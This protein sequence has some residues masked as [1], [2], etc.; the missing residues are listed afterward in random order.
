[1]KCVLH[2]Y[3]EYSLNWV[4]ERPYS[5]LFLDMGLGKTLITLTAIEYLI[6]F[7]QVEKVLV[8]APLTVAQATWGAEIEKWDHLQ[9][10]SLSKVLGSPAQKRIDALE[11]EADIYIINPENIKWLV[12][13]YGKDWP[14]DMLVIDELS[15]FKDHSTQR[16]KALRKVR[17]KA[18]RVIGMTGT[19]APNGLIN[20]WSQQYLIDRGERLEKTIGA[21]RRKYFKPGRTNGHIVYDYVLLPGAEKEIFEKIEDIDVSMKAKDHLNLPERTDNLVEVAMNDK[22]K[23]IYDQMERDY[24]IS[25]DESDIIAS[26]AAVLTNKLIQFAN[27]AVYDEEGE[28]QVIHNRKLD[29]LER[30]IEEAQGEPVLVFYKYKHDLERIQK[31]FKQAKKLDVNAGDVEKWNAGEIPLLLAHPQS[32]GHGLN[33]QKGGHIIVWFGLTWSLEYYQ[34][35]NARLNRQGQENPVVIHHL[36]TKGTVDELVI[37]RLKDKDYDQ[38]ELIHALKAR[39]EEV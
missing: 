26:N 29:A 18:K 13:Y 14:F 2:D 19:P 4:L 1:M 17:P 5:G 10:L 38:E 34:Q 24:V 9:H 12:E 39:I 16:F 11:V 32:A 6:R 15:S 33:L 31:R 21:Y 30:V 20:L 7:G 35:A 22:E 37:R 28:V 23:K 27:G 3:Q 8:I 36:I 25:L